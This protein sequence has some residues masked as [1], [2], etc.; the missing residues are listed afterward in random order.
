M[1]PPATPPSKQ[2]PLPS[3]MMS[4]P[5]GQAMLFGYNPHTPSANFNFADFVNVTPSPAQVAFNKTPKKTP[6]GLKTPIAARETR[7]RLN[8]GASPNIGEH[9]PGKREGLGMDLGAGFH[10]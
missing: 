10:G 2:T 8:F 1:Q 4:T 9:S 6:G 5:G 7:R 3:S